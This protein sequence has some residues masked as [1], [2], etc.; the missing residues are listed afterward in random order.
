MTNTLRAQQ[1]ETVWG[2]QSF[3]ERGV[4][5]Y[6]YSCGLRS[7]L[8]VKHTSKT[9]EDRCSEDRRYL[10]DMLQTTSNSWRGASIYVVF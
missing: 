9:T 6:P 3:C 10:P 1:E 2:V 5:A 8:L 7:S 4:L